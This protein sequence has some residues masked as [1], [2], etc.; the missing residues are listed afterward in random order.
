MGPGA[1]IGE[2]AI[3][4]GGKRTVTLRALT[5]VKVAVAAG[6]QIDKAALAEVSTGHR[7]EEKQ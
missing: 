2:R 6:D 4:E 1:I 5:A 7:K 3:L